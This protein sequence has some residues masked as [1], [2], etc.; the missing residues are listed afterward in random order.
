MPRSLRSSRRHRGAPLLTRGNITPRRPSAGPDL[1][2]HWHRRRAEAAGGESE[3]RPQ[4]LNETIP[5]RADGNCSNLLATQRAWLDRSVISFRLLKNA[6]SERSAPCRGAPCGS[7]TRGRSVRGSGA[8]APPS[9]RNNEGCVRANRALQ[10]GVRGAPGRERPTYP[11]P[12]LPSLWLSRGGSTA[13]EVL[14]VPRGGAAL[15]F[16]AVRDF[17]GARGPS[18]CPRFRK[19]VPPNGRRLLSRAGSGKH[20]EDPSRRGAAPYPH[21]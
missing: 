17:L 13:A 18:A 6:R 16:P 15:P 8:T 11:H 7:R 14:P 20:R 19:S 3:A 12:S 2:R 5:V 1:R 21:L 9:A 10:R 4:R